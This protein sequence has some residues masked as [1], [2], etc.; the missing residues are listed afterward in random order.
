[1]YT[2]SSTSALSFLFEEND[3]SVD[4]VEKRPAST[5]T[6]GELSL[7]SLSHSREKKNYKQGNVEAKSKQFH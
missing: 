6:L 3:A 7:N 2:F 4:S 1:M 5:D